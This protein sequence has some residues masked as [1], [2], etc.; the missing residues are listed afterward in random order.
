MKM[1][2]SRIGPEE[3]LQICRQTLG[4]SMSTNIEFDDTFL[5]ALLRRGAGML[6]PCS[7]ATLR[8]ALTASLKFLGRDESSLIAKIESAIE[9]LIIGG[10]L[11]ELSE[12]TIADE[13]VKGTWIF[14]AP[15][16]YVVRPSGSIFLTG[17]VPDQDMFLPQYLA[18]RVIHEGLVRVII[19]EPREELGVDL[20]E[21]GVYELSESVWLK[22]PNAET[23]KDHLEKM[24]DRLASQPSCGLVNDLQV[25]DPSK[26]VKYYRG[27]WTPQKSQSGIFI[28]RR[29]Q[30]YGSPIWCLA[31]LENGEAVR[32]IDFPLKKIRW[33]ACDIAWHLQMAID[34]CNNTPQSYRYRHM[35]GGVRL[36]FFSPLPL[37][38]ERRLMIF[39]HPIPRENNLISYYVPV[40]EAEHEEQ[41]LK[42]RLWLVRSNES[43]D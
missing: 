41:F 29:P 5:A 42:E 23:S 11:L 7:S 21:L 30:D 10:D 6:C 40:A 9:G 28:V 25:L 43:D 37:W 2:I 19:P 22:C 31:E 20:C 35:D 1:E 4:L 18:S 39:G 26:S 33:R 14:T 38:S 32:L 16:G 17:I 24:L 3:V 8:A 13:S 15:P 27:R 34:D 12:V 36:D